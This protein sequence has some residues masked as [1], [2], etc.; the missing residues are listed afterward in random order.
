M[1]ILSTTTEN[2]T[3]SLNRERIV[4]LLVTLPVL[5]LIVACHSQVRSE[6]RPPEK[7]VASPSPRDVASLCE[8][9]KEIEILPIKDEVVVPD[10]AYN[11]LV[12]AGE[13][14]IPCLIKKITDETKMSDPRQA[15]KV[16]FLFVGDTAF[17]MLVRIAKIDFVELLPP[18]VRTAYEGDQGIY[19]YFGRIDEDNNRKKLQDA[20]VKWYEKKY[21]RSL[22]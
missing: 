18:D 21:G 7:P 1:K 13:D 20:A 6:L 9:I 11:A 8:S 12:S 5:T 10:P 17:F 19:G 16:G 3:L 15:P 2:R 4:A 22:P 14:A